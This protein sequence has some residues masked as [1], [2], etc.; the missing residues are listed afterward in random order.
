MTP[1]PSAVRA[2]AID[3]G[4]SV[5]ARGRVSAEVLGAYRAA[6]GGAGDAVND[7]KASGRTVAKAPARRAAAK[8]A[9]A[10]TAVVKTSAVTSSTAKKAPAAK[11][12]GTTTAAT[13]ASAGGDEA[14]GQ[15]QAPAKT[16]TRRAPARKAAAA[17]KAPARKAPNR[18]ALPATGVAEAPTSPEAGP[19]QAD[20]PATD[21]SAADTGATDTSGVDSGGTQSP[22][23]TAGSPA[24]T[25]VQHAPDGSSDDS[26]AA[27]ADDVPTVADEARLARLEEHIASLVARVAELEK[28]PA[29]K[30]SR[31]RRRSS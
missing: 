25:A 8:K 27:R 3:Q 22:V 26:S 12:V 20:L 2:W 21:A 30:P 31:F 28:G 15:T 24:G 4:I 17:R 19:T 6:H 1:A 10:K 11:P 9:P 13:A 23:E 5:S 18:K 29:P 7:A 14:T 16:A